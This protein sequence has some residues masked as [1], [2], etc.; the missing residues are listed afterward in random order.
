MA[1]WTGVNINTGAVELPKYDATGNY[2][3]IYTAAVTTALANGDTITGPVIPAGVF[4]VD[5]VAAPDD[6]DSAAS[7][8]IQ[9][10]VGYKND[11]GTVVAGFLKTGNTTA[12]T[13]GVAHMDVPAAFG[14]TFTSN[15]TVQAVITAAAG[16]AVAGAFRLGAVLTA[17]P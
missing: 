15:T 12:G 8:L 13:G 9:F 11:S 16:T 4:V 2:S 5:V 3:E 17:D 14:K 7:P 10:E 6:L 1:T